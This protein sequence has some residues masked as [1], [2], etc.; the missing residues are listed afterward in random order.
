M[1]LS[2]L[3]KITPLFI[4]LLL[5]LFIIPNLRLMASKKKNFLPDGDDRIKNGVMIGGIS[6]F[7]I[8]L[9]AL[10]ISISLPYLLQIDELRS[11][12]EPAA[13]RI[14]QIVVGC[15]ILFIT[16]LKD[17]LNGTS[18]FVKM[19]ALLIASVMFPATGLW[20]DNLHGLFGIENLS[21]Y[22]GIPLT[23]I[24][25]CYITEAFSLLDGIDGLSSGVGA[26][27]I[28]TFLLFSIWFDS[29]LISFVAAATLGV[30]IPL[31]F[32]SLLSSK[33]GNTLMGN[34]GAYVL[35][36]IV[37]YLSIGL[38]HSE[39]MPEGMFM[40]CL[41][42]LFVPMLDVLRVVNSRVRDNRTID[43]PDRN[44]FN[45]KLLRTGIPRRM[46]PV[47]IAGLM[48]IFVIMNT[49]GV[50]CHWNPTIMVLLDIVLWITIHLTLNYFI[51]E[52]QRKGFYREWEKAYGE[53]SWYANIPHETLKRKA[54]TYGNMHLDQDKV[55]E[56]VAFISDGM[57]GLE[58]QIKRA[59]DL[60]LSL[61]CLIIFSPLMLLSYILI[62]IDDGGPAI[63]KQERVG[64]YGHPFYIYKF[65]S[66]RLDAEKSGPSLSHANGNNDPRLT[67]VG[68]FLRAHHLDE[69]PQLWNVFVGDIAFVGY[70]PERK[71]YI[72]KIMKEDPRY[73]FLYQIRPGVTSYATLYNGY[74]DTMEKMLRRLELD[75]YYLK[76]RSLWFDVKILGLTFLS[77][78]SGKKF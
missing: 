38:S 75:L 63:Y 17:D 27:I 64:R 57:N 37:S 35:G 61:I 48:G 12:V 8:I 4:S 24:L 55:V 47:T 53:D 3:L 59:V 68:S 7:P 71:F 39:R 33:W 20:I 62:K 19:G 56:D 77:I 31:C 46:I 45:H 26:I 65:R 72:D 60:I 25:V 34:S 29:T 52:H 36:Y 11:T 73:A 18:G 49:S 16:G 69:L 9:I 42:A 67:K 43:R 22:V 5:G 50:I 70:R 21:P 13:M 28:F 66:M 15:M 30:A 2:I 76:H 32:R 23:V 44:Q 40:I 74:T 54:Q 41:G 58:R 6:F 1:I 51:H 78:I 14:M 10:C